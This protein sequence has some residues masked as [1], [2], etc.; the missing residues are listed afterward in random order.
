MLIRD[1]AHKYKELYA[2]QRSS[3]L[4]KMLMTNI[5]RFVL[6]SILLVGLLSIGFVTLSAPQVYASPQGFTQNQV[7]RAA[8]KGFGIEGTQPNTVHGVLHNGHTNDYVVLEGRFSLEKKSDKAQYYFTDAAGD[9]IAVDISNS[10]NDAPPMSG[11]SYY[12][13]GQVQESFFSTSIKV[14]EFTPMG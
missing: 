14:I 4:R 8:P 6:P 3:T 7:Q 9:S 5:G 12:L 1:Q 10:N 2:P 11:V 13:W